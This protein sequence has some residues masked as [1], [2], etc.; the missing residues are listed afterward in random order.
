MKKPIIYLA[1]PY[2]HEQETIRIS[3]VYLTQLIVAKL[4]SEGNIIYS[5]IC[6]N[7]PLAKF[8]PDVLRHD[9]GFWMGIDLPILAKAD[10]LWVLTLDGWSKSRGVARE[11]EFALSLNMPITYLAGGDEGADIEDRG[12]L[13]RAEPSA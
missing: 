12:N 7:A 5:P 10:F 8:I 4:L 3:R 9:H 13:T 1:S 6:H 11:I 2:W